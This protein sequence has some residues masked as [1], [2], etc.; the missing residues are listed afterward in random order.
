MSEIL[1]TI[2]EFIFS[3]DFWFYHGWFLTFLWVLLSLAGITIKKYNITLHLLSFAIVDYI[4]LFFGGA[5]LYR[6]WTKGV[7]F[8]EWPLIKQIHIVGGNFSCYQRGHFV[9]TNDYSARR[10][11]NCTLWRETKQKSSMVW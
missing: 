9:I 1:S 7:S 11:N 8:W 4:T 6:V 5:G 2:S 3:K 10:R